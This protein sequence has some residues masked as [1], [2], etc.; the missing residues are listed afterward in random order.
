MTKLDITFEELDLI[1]AAIESHI[2]HLCN[3][4]TLSHSD[5]EETLAFR[6]KLELLRDENY[7][8]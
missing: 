1:Q 8:Y 3:A 2:R 6:R 5:M 7:D 4:V